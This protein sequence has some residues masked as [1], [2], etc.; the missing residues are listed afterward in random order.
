MATGTIKKEN[1]I[2]NYNPS[3]IASGVSLNGASLMTVHGE[4][5]VFRAVINVTTA[6]ARGVELF[7][8]PN[9]NYS[10]ATTNNVLVF[11]PGTA[12]ISTVSVINST[13][14][15]MVMHENGLTVGR[16][17]IVLFGQCS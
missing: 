2:T 14:R 7:Q 4:F 8:L 16:W 15:I 10:T 9:F 1:R 5:F 11:K 6:L 12:E 17:E 3:L 13:K